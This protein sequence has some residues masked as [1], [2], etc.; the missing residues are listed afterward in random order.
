MG[1][2]F[3]VTTYEGCSSWPEFRSIQDLYKDSCAKRSGVPLLNHIEEGLQI[4]HNLDADVTTAQAYCLHPI[5][6]DDKNLKLAFENWGFVASACETRYGHTS[7]PFILTMEY[8]WVANN[9]LS[10]DYDPNKKPKLSV[11]P[12]VNQM[13]IADK[14]QNFK[15]FL[16]HK[17]KYDNKDILQKYFVQWLA[18][19]E[20]TQDTI[21]WIKTCH[22]WRIILPYL[23]A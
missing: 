3:Y 4:L 22:D 20:I 16:H 17:D 2:T 15:D 14:L 7:K 19:L 5:F 11:L 23:K 13:L 9:Y 8:R 10:K 18:E 21:S 6:Q 1:R 12:E